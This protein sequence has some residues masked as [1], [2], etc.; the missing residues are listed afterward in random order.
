MLTPQTTGG[1]LTQAPTPPPPPGWYPDPHGG[2]G[3]RYWDGSTWLTTPLVPKP[4]KTSAA[5]ILLIVGAAVFLLLGGCVAIVAIVGSSSKTHQSSA[6]PRDQK[7]SAQ[8]LDPSQYQSIS[9]RDYALL[10]KDPDAAIGRKLIVYGVVTQFDAATGTSEFRANTGAEKAEH[11]YDYDVNTMI[12]AADPAILK[13][14]V[15]KDFVIMHVQVAGAYSYDTQIGGHTVAP[16]FNV[17]IINV[18]GSER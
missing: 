16:K 18:T 15:E 3:Q 13:N 1:P 4:R 10:V 11:R 7:P 12:H 5:K 2:T 8:D 9:P 14:V 6:Q 17:F